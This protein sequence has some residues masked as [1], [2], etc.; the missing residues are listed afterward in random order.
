MLLRKR[1]I[2]WMKGKKPEY[3]IERQMISEERALGAVRSELIRKVGYEG[4]EFCLRYECA[5]PEEAFKA[6]LKLGEILGIDVTLAGAPEGAVGPTGG[7]PVKRD[8]ITL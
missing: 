6:K 4:V 2:S 8:L 1:E 5:D 7:K 3:K